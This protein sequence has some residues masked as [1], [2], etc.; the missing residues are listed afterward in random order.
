[1]NI[2]SKLKSTYLLHLNCSKD[3]PTYIFIFLN[4]KKSDNLRFRESNSHKVTDALSRD[5]Q[6][7]LHFGERLL[8][9][10][11]GNIICRCQ[12]CAT[13][14]TPT[15][16]VRFIPCGKII[17]DG[18][19]RKYASCNS[20]AR[21]DTIINLQLESC[22]EKNYPATLKWLL[23]APKEISPSVAFGQSCGEGPAMH[24]VLRNSTT[25]EE[26]ATVAVFTL[27]VLPAM[28]SNHFDSDGDHLG[29]L[30][31]ARIFHFSTTL[32][33]VPCH[34]FPSLNIQKSSKS[35]Q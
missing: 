1:M 25:T 5:I 14:L 10:W 21:T 19:V 35:L 11:A 30:W 33:E 22:F 23:T 32:H 4:S 9:P 20:E 7:S 34:I 26:P 8:Q 18:R 12:S 17:G 3:K 15:R 28:S 13:N 16:S 2:I 29:R 24:L 27:L 6:K 31:Y